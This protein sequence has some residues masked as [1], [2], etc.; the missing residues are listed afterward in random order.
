[1]HR[2]NP[3]LELQPG[4]GGSRGKVLFQEGGISVLQGLNRAGRK[5]KNNVSDSNDLVQK[6]KEEEADKSEE[7]RETN[8][9]KGGGR[10]EKT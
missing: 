4:G 1:M 8:A 5:N 6:Q 2:S 3:T 10:K 7:H 9:V